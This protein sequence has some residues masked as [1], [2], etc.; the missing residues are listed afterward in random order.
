MPS[1]IQQ[2]FWVCQ[3]NASTGSSIKEGPF[4]DIGSAKSRCQAIAAA[5]IGVPFIV[6]KTTAGY[7][8]DSPQSVPLE[9]FQPGP[10]EPPLDL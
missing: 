4:Y 9:F 7:A 10:G 6:V 2:K 8:T 1:L 5:N 3:E